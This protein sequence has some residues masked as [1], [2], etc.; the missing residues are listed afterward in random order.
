MSVLGQILAQLTQLTAKEIIQFLRIP[1]E[2]GWLYSKPF[3][4]YPS[5]IGWA[6]VA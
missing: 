2:R 6:I 1:C 4:K 3:S 5:E